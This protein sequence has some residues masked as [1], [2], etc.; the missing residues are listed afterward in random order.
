VENWAIVHTVAGMLKAKIIA[1]RLE[2]EGIPSWLKYEAVGAIYG[3]TINGLGGVDILV[4]AE[5]LEKAREILSQS[6][7]EA[8][9][10]WQA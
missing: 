9:I 3:I 10:D 8:D 6:Y 1:G 2:V 7:D 4:P 5:S